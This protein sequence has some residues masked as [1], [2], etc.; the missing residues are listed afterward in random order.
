MIL[1]E[2]KPWEEIMG[3]LAQAGSIFLVG[4]SGCAEASG[5]GG[6]A[7]LASVQARLEQA[8]KKVAG[9]AS[10][11]F[12]CQKALVRSRLRA[13]GRAVLAAD[14][15]LVLSCGIGVQAVAAV[16]NKPCHP[17]C[18]TISLGGIRGKWPGSER[19]QECGDCVLHYTG[20]ICPLTACTKGLLNGAC[21][22]ASGGK[23]E[24]DK[25]RD[26][27]WELI[28][29]RLQQLGRLD[30]LK[31]FLPPKDYRKM[32]PGAELRAST[33]YALEQPESR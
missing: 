22:G 13:K 14:A 17:G 8:G 15:F 30:N 19:C 33:F 20:G 18:N 1:S 5:T 25:T 6:P 26:C 21:G 10:I 11:D 29:H 24:A 16:V 32:L 4:C 12:L 7:Q 23:C 9:S 3:Y 28:Y 27:G 2:L 31:V